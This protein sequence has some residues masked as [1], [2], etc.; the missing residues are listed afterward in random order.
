M[1]A[2]SATRTKRTKRTD[3]H[4][5]G[6]IVPV[7]YEFVLHYSMPSS[8]GGFP[9]P[10][11]G[12]NCELDHAQM[13]EGG[14]RQLGAHHPDGGCCVVALRGRFVATGGTGQCSVCSTH[15][16]NGEVWQHVPTGEFIH[17][18]CN[19]AHKYGLLADRSAHELALGRIKA[20][21][22]A[23]LARQRNAEERTAFL[24]EH[25]GLEAALT[26][27]GEHPILADLEGKFQRDRALSVKQVALALK[28]AHELDHPRAEDVRVDAPTG[29]QTFEGRVI[30]VKSQ[31]NAFGTTL[32]MT[33]KITTPAGSWL[34]WGTAP[35]GLLD[36]TVNHA[37]ALRGVKGSAGTL[38][39]VT[40]T[41]QPG[42]ERGFALMKRPRGIVLER[43]C[44][45]APDCS[46]CAEENMIASVVA[47]F[48]GE[49]GPDA[50]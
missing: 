23:A 30:S 8:E 15:F 25:P 29:K 27:G 48:Q 13:G 28:I 38:V 2:E 19:C 45:G 40:A 6:A 31:E 17:I 39:R 44:G 37:G 32:R 36:A 26:R 5:P 49:G 47:F 20:A 7:H 4:R 16:V 18:G 12:I 22:G 42:R 21:A 24:A 50:Q 10:G 9:V 46:Q 3:V 35:A 14:V 1:E 41:L 33:V 43:A 11:F 34:A